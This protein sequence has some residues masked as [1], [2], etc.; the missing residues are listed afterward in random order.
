VKRSI[1]IAGALAIG[2]SPALAQ[3]STTSPLP[4]PRPGV[5][6][7]A[8]LPGSNSFTENQIRERL[9]GNG[10]TGVTG[11]RK[12]DQ[13]VWRGTAMRNGASTPVA[14]DYRGN[15]FQQ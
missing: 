5:D 12:D 8:P 11:L 14:V 4:T 3:T 6:T 1:M 7:T 13:G 15:I 2:L 10:F 9:E